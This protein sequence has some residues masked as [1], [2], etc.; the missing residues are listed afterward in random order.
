MEVE[1]LLL[2]ATAD[3]DKAMNS[4]TEKAQLKVAC[5]LRDAESDK[6]TNFRAAPFLVAACTDSC[7]AVCTGS[8]MLLTSCWRQKPKRT[9]Q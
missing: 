4:D 6:A 5:V 1:H 2:D 7:T 9:M 3:K 8:W